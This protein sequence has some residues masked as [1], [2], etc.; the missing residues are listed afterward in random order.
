MKLIRRV[1]KATDKYADNYMDMC[2][3]KVSDPAPQDCMEGLCVGTG[4]KREF[5]SP[6]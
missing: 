4:F 5:G 2:P 1:I 3:K 6:L